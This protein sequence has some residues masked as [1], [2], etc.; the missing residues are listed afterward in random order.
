VAQDLPRASTLEGVRFTAQVLVPHAIQGLFRRRPKAV[1]VATKLNA[2]G[3]AV[4]FIGGLRR[5][6][7]PGPIWVKAG[8]DNALLVLST[9]DVRRVL[10]DAPE[11]FAADPEAKKAGMSHFQPDA[12]TI[13][14][15]ELWR[16]RRRFQ[17]AVL[18]TGKPLH[19][20]AEHIRE[21]VGEEAAKL[22]GEVGWEAFNRSLLR[23]SRRVILGDAAG[24][25]ERV[26]E[27]LGKLMDEANN[28]PK[29]RSESYEPFTAKVREYVAAAEPG[30]LVGLFAEAPADHDVRVEGQV[31]HWMFA[32]GDTL[33]I[34]AFRAL[35]LIASH[36]T[37]RAQLEEELAG[38]DL[39]TA[40][41]VAGLDYLEGCLEEALR[42]WPS[43]PLLS[44]VTTE[45]VQWNGAVVPSGSQIL[46]SNLFNH[47]DS[48]THAYADRFAPEAWTQGSAA[49]DW[50]FN[51]FSHGPQGCPGAGLALFIGK[52]LLAD[53]LT[54]KQV[55][56]LEPEI[57]PDKPLPHMLDFFSLRFA[58]EPLA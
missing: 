13:S 47:R 51:H 55:R 39:G 5:S 8:T 48:E 26:S 7:G 14:R 1:A 43:T 40:E 19:R 42:L 10:E 53:L 30:S 25:D 15:G 36:P 16:K 49:D 20:L 9:E 35:A 33:A 12:L 38:A 46:I 58:L 4:S 17:E 32:M 54:K 24:D 41:G 27:L 44:R 22:S 23:I 3:H 31:P 52:A 34:N 29:E 6:H 37:Q 50:A 57:D 2:D 45:D 28:R 21:L 11:P 56:L 18:D